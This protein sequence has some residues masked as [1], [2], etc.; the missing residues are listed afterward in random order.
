MPKH[1]AYKRLLLTGAAMSALNIPAVHAQQS[2]GN[3]TGIETVIVSAERRDQSV[4]NV[5]STVQAFTGQTLSDLNVTTFHDLLKFTPNVTYGNN[6]PGQGEITMRGLSNGFRGNQSSGTI[7][8]F[9]NVAL[10]L[11]D[12]SMQFPARN[13]DVYVVDMQRIE[14]L[15]GPQGTLFGGGAEAGAVRYITNK[16]DL[17]AIDGKSRPVTALPAMALPNALN[18]MINVPI[19]DDKLAVRLVIYDDR[20]GGYIDNVSSTF[21]RS[22][23]DLGNAYFNILPTGG[24]A[25]TISPPVRAAIVPCPR[26]GGQQS[27]RRARQFQP[28]RARRRAF[29]RRLQDR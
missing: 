25:P 29:V 27:I 18:G 13:L 22:N 16:P 7:A 9:P 28:G 14:V 20:Q 11:D 23:Q 2:T 1:F 21:T 5:P 19:I 4:E 6:G 10:Y 15:E 12:Q 3:Q 8:N 17:S 24:F 26:A